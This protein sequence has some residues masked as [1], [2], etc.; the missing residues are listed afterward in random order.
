L[1]VRAS[2]N[3]VRPEGIYDGLVLFIMVPIASWLFE[4]GYRLEGQV[5]T[6]FITVIMT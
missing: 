6:L 5:P 4:V 1:A 2:K 3:K